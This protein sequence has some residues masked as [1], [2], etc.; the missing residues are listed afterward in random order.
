MRLEFEKAE[1]PAKPR[2]RKQ[3]EAKEESEAT[4]ETQAEGSDDSN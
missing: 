4:V 3:L 1:K 2:I